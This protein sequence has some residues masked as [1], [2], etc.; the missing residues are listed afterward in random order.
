LLA[1]FLQVA[2]LVQKGEGI[3]L[4]TENQMQRKFSVLLFTNTVYLWWKTLGKGRESAETCTRLI[5]IGVLAYVLYFVFG[6]CLNFFQTVL[7]VWVF[8][9]QEV[10]C[11]YQ[12]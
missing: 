12:G 4:K 2:T 9:V 5:A 8:F 10:F 11:R 7:C 3:E 6:F 1:S